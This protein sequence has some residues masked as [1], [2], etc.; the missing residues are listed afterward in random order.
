M[1]ILVTAGN[2]RTP[3]DRVRCITNVFSGRTGA[4]IAA[5]AHTR[6][7]AVTLLTS[8]PEALDAIPATRPRSA[9]SWTIHRYLTFEELE[10]LMAAA[11]PGGGFDTVI[12]AAAVNDYHAAGVFVRQGGEMVDVSAGKVKSDHPELWLRL[13]RAPKLIDRIRPDWAFRGTLVKFKLEVDVTAERLI[14]IA[15]QSRAHSH[16]DLM[17]ANTLDGAADWAYIGSGPGRYDRIVRARLAAALLDRVEALGSVPGA[18]P[19][20]S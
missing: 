3:I 20:V 17:V 6:G 8:H 5:H 11:I 12:H 14:E 7:H 16:A 10:G 4:Q 15:E 13:T 9:P 19:P 2:T 18:R 1:N